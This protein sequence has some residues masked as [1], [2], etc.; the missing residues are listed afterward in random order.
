MENRKCV[1]LDETLHKRLKTY[2]ASQGISITSYADYCISSLLFAEEI[3]SN[4]EYQS[5]VKLIIEMGS[6]NIPKEKLDELL[7][8]QK[9]II[10]DV[11]RG[12]Y[13]G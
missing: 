4:V 1:M 7:E 10:K 11:E 13:V 5:L 6:K 2:C 9:Q 8:R 3:E 12:E